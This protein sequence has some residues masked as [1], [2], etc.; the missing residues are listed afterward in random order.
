MGRGWTVSESLGSLDDREQWK[1]RVTG[2]SRI[3]PGRPYS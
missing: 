3:L 1:A 2:D